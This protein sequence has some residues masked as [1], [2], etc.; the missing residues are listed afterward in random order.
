MK[1]ICVFC[2]S[3][4]GSSPEFAQA[5]AD[6]GRAIAA[7]G[8]GLVFGGGSV[9]LMRI[10][11]DAALDAGGEVIGV[12]PGFLIEKEHVHPRLQD[13]RVVG[14]MHERKALMASLAGAFIALPGGFGTIEE[15]FEMLTWSQLG[16]HAKPCG[17]LNVAGYYTHLIAFL[18]QAVA[19]EFLAGEN[20]RAT[21]VETDAVQMVQHMLAA[22][23]PGA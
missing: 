2:G 11:A 7:A 12:I 1:R 15:I 4:A 6:T 3:R 19:A 20:W 23:G 14:T 10:V 16:L 17:F 18:D 13:L 8:A 22:I 9:G 5:A 21:T